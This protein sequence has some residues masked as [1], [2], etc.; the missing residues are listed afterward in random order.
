MEA[1]AERNRARREEAA[2]VAAH[3]DEQERIREENNAR[4]QRERDHRRG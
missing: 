2:R 3:Y 4:E 1:I